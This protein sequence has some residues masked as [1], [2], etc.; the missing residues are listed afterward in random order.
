MNGLTQYFLKGGRISF[1]YTYIWIAVRWC[2]PL[3]SDACLVLLTVL[4]S[5]LAV[6]Y[7]E[8]ISEMA[9]TNWRMVSLALPWLLEYYDLVLPLAIIIR[10]LWMVFRLNQ[11]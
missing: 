1:I 4:L 3:D 8:P 5:A 2:V 9:R 11:T 10:G 7:E 6:H